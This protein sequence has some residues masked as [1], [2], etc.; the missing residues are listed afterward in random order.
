MTK[1][2]GVSDELR[3]TDAGSNLVPVSNDGLAL[4]SIY[5]YIPSGILGLAAKVGDTIVGMAVSSFTS[6][7]LT[8][9]LLAVSIRNES[10][11]WPRL[12]AAP[13][14][15]VSLLSDQQG[16]AARQLAA[17]AENSR[18]DGVLHGV[19]ESGAVLID[20]ASALFETAVES[21]MHA[22]D[23]TIVLLR[24]HTSSVH[25]NLSPMVFH[26]SGFGSV[27]MHS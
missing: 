7:S 1:T 24:L 10:A 16:Y 20:D 14:I 25:P 2:Q 27:T 21:T 19:A 3:R 4:R 13:I 22:G 9:P 15:G 17:P 6:V 8:P 12:L 26:R 11:T 23:H 5:G 18:F